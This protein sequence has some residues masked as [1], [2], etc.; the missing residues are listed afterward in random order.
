M[1][2]YDYDLALDSEYRTQLQHAA[3]DEEMPLD[4]SMTPYF[5]FNRNLGSSSK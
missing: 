4:V 5:K 3:Q 2:E 1:A